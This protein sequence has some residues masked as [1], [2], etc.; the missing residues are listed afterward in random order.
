MKNRV[1][2]LSI[3]FLI[4]LFGCVSRSDVM[5]TWTGH[6]IDELIMIAGAPTNQFIRSDGGVTYTW[7]NYYGNRQ[8]NETYSANAEGVIT[9][10]SYTGC[11]GLVRA[12]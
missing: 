1:F 12:L 11:T 4:F 9:N 10:Y 7:I 6:R 5:Q 3:L 2:A 8:C